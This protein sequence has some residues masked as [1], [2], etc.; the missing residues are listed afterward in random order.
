M[1]TSRLSSSLQ[2]WLCY[3]CHTLR[4]GNFYTVLAIMKYGNFV[5]SSEKV[6]KVVVLQFFLN[7]FCY[8]LRA[9]HGFRKMLN[10]M[11]IWPGLEE[12]TEYYSDLIDFFNFISKSHYV[13]HRNENLMFNRKYGC[14]K[15]HFILSAIFFKFSPYNN[16]SVHLQDSSI[17]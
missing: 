3:S 17:S 2:T 1:L 13:N 16:T 6:A 10:S 15:I 14:N 7:M 12:A 8:M 9:C 11:G 4:K 5:Y